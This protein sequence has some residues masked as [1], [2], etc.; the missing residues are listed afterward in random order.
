MPSHQEPDAGSETSA[1]AAQLAR[2]E[3]LLD[4]NE[5]LVAGLVHDLR[6]PLMAINLSAEVALA[7]SNEDAVQQAARRIRSSSERMS[8]IFDHLINLSRVTNAVPGLDLQPSSLQEALDA[9]L[10]EAG[11]GHSKTRFEVKSD[12]RLE[13]VFDSALIRRAIANVV[14]TCVTHVEASEAVTI[15]VD[16]SHRDR[17]WIR[18]SIPGVV[19][20]EIQESLFVS[21]PAIRG[22]EPIGM[23]LGL[24]EIDP[25]VRA[26]G[27]SVVGR[28]RAP[29]G[30]VFELLL[31]RDASARS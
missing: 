21:G 7:R 28:S 8:R 17:F 5:R 6:T 14:G 3:R 15:H 20:A 19:P 18:V 10:G 1:L 2:A 30:T 12:G 29:H 4:L 9:V 25:L 27:G 31:P 24:H 11:A 26:H 22:L 16:G 13:G 23:G